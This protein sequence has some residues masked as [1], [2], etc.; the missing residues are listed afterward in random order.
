MNHKDVITRYFEADSDFLDAAFRRFC[1]LKMVSLPQ[2]KPFFYAFSKGLSR[3]ILREEEV[4]FPLF[5]KKTGMREYGPAA[6]MRSEHRKIRTL[7]ERMKKKIGR[8]SAPVRAEEEALLEMLTEHHE[9]EGEILHAALD[10]MITPGEAAGVFLDM[11]RIPA[12][13]DGVL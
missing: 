8:D 11:E 3:H 13:T 5:E 12:E 2:A 6:L 4:L 1:E 9:R 10:G 7:L